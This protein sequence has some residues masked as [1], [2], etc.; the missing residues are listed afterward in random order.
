MNNAMVKSECENIPEQYF[1]F[2]NCSDMEKDLCDMEM[3]SIFG[4]VP[5]DKILFSNKDFDPSRSP[6]IKFKINIRYVEDSV[7]EIINKIRDE[8]IKY[9]QN[10]DNKF[11]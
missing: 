5:K 1:Y 11:N 7:E 9:D 8:E 4:K 2:T 10:D 3:K 6:F